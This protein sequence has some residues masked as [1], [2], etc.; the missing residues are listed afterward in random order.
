MIV[1]D[2]ETTGVDPQRHSIASIGAVDFRAPAEQFYTACRPFDGAAFDGASLA[3]NGFTPEELADPS[4]PTLEEALRRFFAWAVPRSGPALAGHNTHF[5]HGFL[6]AGARRFRLAWPFGFR[7]IDLHSV[8]WTRM[9][10][11]GHVPPGGTIR[12]SV[13]FAY[14]GLPEEPK[15]H[16]GL[17]GAKMEAEAFSRLLYG[18]PLLDEYASHAVPGHLLPGRTTLL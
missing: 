13:V 16:H 12:S 10:Q 2:V 15:P 1:V 3:V 17:T 4:L 5:D 18:K 11:T 9:V 14:A 8:A 7:V 6:Q